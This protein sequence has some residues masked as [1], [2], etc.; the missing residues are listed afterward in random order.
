MP[1]DIDDNLEQ[2][3]TGDVTCR[4]CGTGVG[5]GS[6]EFLARAHWREQPSTAA[7]TSVV[8]AEPALF[9]DRP[10]LLRQAFCS[11]CYTVLLTEIVPEGEPRFRSKR[12][13]G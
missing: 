3:D 7:G 8:R 13:H 4:H 11:G 6:G 12:L 2:T 5:D 10:I 9:V 1:L